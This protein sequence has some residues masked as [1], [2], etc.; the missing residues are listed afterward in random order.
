M[1]KTLIN[2]STLLLLLSGCNSSSQKS[3]QQEQSN[4]DTTLNKSAKEYFGSISDATI[5]IYELGE[6]EKKLLFSENT[7]M[8]EKLDAIGNFNA[9]TQSL[10]SQHFY[11]YELTGGED[12]DIDHNNIIDSTP[13]PNS[14]T[15][16]AI[17]KGKNNHVAWWGT[18]KSIRNL[19][20]SE[21]F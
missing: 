3:T 15:Y 6:G 1:Y 11:L 12:W 2:I 5:N 13:T 18:K 9:H 7:T 20:L 16:R 8:G 19:G 14:S 10:N 17:Y 4:I 21:K